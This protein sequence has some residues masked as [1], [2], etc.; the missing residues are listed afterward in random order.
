V[1]FRGLGEFNLD[2]RAVR[3]D[4]PLIH[5][6]DQLRSCLEGRVP[7][8]VTH[9]R[10]GCNHLVDVAQRRTRL[11]ADLASLT[12]GLWRPSGPPAPPNTR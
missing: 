7:P 9:R 6:A 8:G 2:D 3:D 11:Q 12:A 10:Q 4:D 5:P 1:A